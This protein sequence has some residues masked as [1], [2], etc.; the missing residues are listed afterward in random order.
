MKQRLRRCPLLLGQPFTQFFDDHR[1]QRQFVIPPVFRVGGQHDD[2]RILGIQIQRPPVTAPFESYVKM[3][4]F[5]QALLVVLAIAI[6]WGS[7]CY[8]AFTS[9]LLILPMAIPIGAIVMVGL[10]YLGIGVAD[11]LLNSQKTRKALLRR[12]R[13]PMIQEI[14]QEQDDLKDLLR[15]QELA[16]ANKTLKNRYKIDKV[17]ASGG[18]GETYIAKDLQR[19]ND[20]E[21]VVKH[22]HPVSNHPS[23]LRLASK[24]FKR[25]ADTL[26]MLGKK[27]DQIPR[28]L[29]Y[30]EEDEEFYLVQEFIAGHPLSEEVLLSRQFSEARVVNIL[31]EILQILQFVHEEGVIH[32]DVKP[33]NIIKRESD[34]KLVLIDFG[35]VK[36]EYNK[37]TSDETQTNLTVGIGTQGYMAPE[38][39][40][41]KPDY[42]SDIYSVGMMGIQALT[43]YSP[44]QLQSDPETKEIVWQEKAP[45][46]VSSGLANII[47]KMVRYDCRDRYQSAIE[48]LQD[49]QKLSHSSLSTGTIAPFPMTPSEEDLSTMTRPWPETF[50]SENLPPTQPPP[51]KKG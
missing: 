8:V 35:A 40:F 12:S 11:N 19:P 33:S 26:E 42:N 34:G 41:G 44:S 48:V 20:P 28:L 27:H 5:V 51:Q 49:L 21:C 36:D 13:A 43:G 46:K 24:M 14:M 47:S 6:A 38:Q 25:E 15:E 4:F 39:G 2:G 45:Q 7:A 3:L 17:L 18:F 30:F 37:L 32:R 9:G 50:G 1:M 16:I 22:L 23:H 10:S 29:A 31:K